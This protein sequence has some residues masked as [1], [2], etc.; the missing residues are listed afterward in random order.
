[1]QFHHDIIDTLKE[2]QTFAVANWFQ[3]VKIIWVNTIHKTVALKRKNKHCI[4]IIHQKHTEA[5]CNMWCKVRRHIQFTTY[6][7]NVLFLLRFTVHANK[8][9]QIMKYFTKEQKSVTMNIAKHR[10]RKL[11]RANIKAHD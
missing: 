6:I 11:I 8:L 4:T 1:M 2:E 3:P 5:S 7:L 9:S 10:N